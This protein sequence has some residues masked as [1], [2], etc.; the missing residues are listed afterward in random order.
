LLERLGAPSA[1]I[2]DAT[3]LLALSFAAGLVR[4]TWRYR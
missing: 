4:A 1:G 3:L 2:E